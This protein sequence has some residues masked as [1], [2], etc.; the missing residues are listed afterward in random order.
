MRGGYLRKTAAAASRTTSPAKAPRAAV[1]APVLKVGSVLPGLVAEMP[2]I[3]NADMPVVSTRDVSSEVVERTASL[4]DAGV[5]VSNRASA[6]ASIPTPVPLAAGVKK[7]NTPARSAEDAHGEAVREAPPAIKHSAQS[8]AQAHAMAGVLQRLS[9]PTTRIEAP[10]GLRNMRAVPTMQASPA[11]RLPVV[12]AR[13]PQA[14]QREADAVGESEFS[15]KTRTQ[16]ERHDFSVSDGN[17]E[18]S[19]ASMS[20]TQAMPRANQPVPHEES[21]FEDMRRITTVERHQEVE[22]KQSSGGRFERVS[23]ERAMQERMPAKAVEQ[24]ARMMSRP[25]EHAA[26]APAVALSSNKG[27]RKVRIGQIDVH[28]NNQPAPRRA[29]ERFRPAAGQASGFQPSHEMGRFLL[30]Y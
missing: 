7:M 27:E 29:P 15:T 28:V 19:A 6:E 17:A 10:A 16:I 18:S 11:V 26:S 12:E 21:S 22:V 30:K 25:V 23:Q 13:H 1:P 4:A 9:R 24:P 2:S 14:V 5:H 20:K 3:D 8:A